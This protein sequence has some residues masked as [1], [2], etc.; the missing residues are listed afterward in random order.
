MYF[1]NR[2]FLAR[3]GLAVIL[4]SLALTTKLIVGGWF[5]IER[6][7]LL[8]FAAVTV[9]ALYGGLGPAILAIT[10]ASLG[11]AYFFLPN[12]NSLHLDHVS[13][14]R[15]VT[16]AAETLTVSLFISALHRARRRSEAE[17][18]EL[19]R[20]RELFKN[21]FEHAAV[22]LA[23]VGTDGRFLRVNQPL[24]D[25][26]GYTREEL[27]RRSFQEIT[28]P[29]DLAA[30]LQR[31][32]KL[33]AGD[34]DTY[35]IE[36][37]YFR[38]DGSIIWI[39]LTV[40]IVR[41]TATCSDYFISVIEDITKRKRAEE[42]ILRLNERLELRVEERTRE[43][44]EA[45]GELRAFTYSIAHDLRAPLTS[46]Q[47]LAQALL[48][49]CG[50]TMTPEAREYASRISAASARMDRMTQDL[51][52]YSQVHRTE[53]V[54]E[55]VELEKVV[56]EALAQASAQMAATGAE[57]RV[58]RPMPAVIAHAATLQQI[59]ANLL[60]NAIKFVPSGAVPR[61]VIRAEP[62]GRMVRLW[63]EDNGIG[64]APEHRERIFGVFERLHAGGGYSGT[65]IGLAIVRRGAERMGGSTDVESM[66]GEGSRF[67]VELPMAG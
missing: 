67:W 29:D 20:S 32:R 47:G 34:T 36:K 37:R 44:E 27:L 63:V 17:A 40:S 42:E 33:L 3:Y 6:P 56:D 11:T 31:L 35:S 9:T 4:V 18:I 64:I 48:D 7:F 55:P 38:A 19:G 28:H 13:L 60:S 12:L 24:C 21:T 51:L 46:L 14:L 57:T 43:L 10:L 23:H 53:L 65:G 54:L 8:L 61:I 30:D 25:M 5:G 52:G 2:S 58:E 59:I 45:N 50:E 22:G 49:D 66:P 39:N 16:F 41:S 15:L 26:L 62:R 1:S